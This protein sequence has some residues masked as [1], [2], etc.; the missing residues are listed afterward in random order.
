M[1]VRPDHHRPIPSRWRRLL[2][3]AHPALPRPVDAVAER[4]AQTRPRVR[5][6]IVGL[7][8]IGV[9][10]AVG[11]RIQAAD[12]R[13]GGQPVT[14][15]VA[16]HDLWVGEPA[17][18]TQQLDLPPPAVPPGAVKAVDADARLALALPEGS[19]LT[20]R[21]LDSSGPSAGLDPQLRAV[22]VEVD[23]GWGVVP[24][25]WVDVWVLGVHGDEPA[26]VARGRPVL[27][28]RGE[29]AQVSA[30]LGLADDE[31]GPTTEGIAAG[32]V[33]LTLAPA[34][35]DSAGADGDG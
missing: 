29:G 3:G 30:L 16:E 34:A 14:V 9:T 35:W 21:H 26:L 8:F 20:E 5:T 32:R 31:V 1:P 13:W 24:G 18:A 22:P 7:L 2:S 28:V 25:G 10:V 6:L 19:V 11:A 15:L 12:A 4:W 33:L 27:E 23:E 17:T